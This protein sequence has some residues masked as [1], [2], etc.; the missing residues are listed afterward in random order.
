MSKQ[1]TSDKVAAAPTI[2]SQAVEHNGFVFVSGQVPIRLDGSIVE[3][4]VREKFEQ[5]VQNIQ[6]ILEAA[7]TTVANCVSVTIY[8]TDMGQLPELN[9]IYA[10]F[11]GDPLPARAAIGV[12][13]LPLGATIELSVVAAK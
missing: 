3:G 10:Q 12:Q 4:G 11:F 9:E 1:I 8:L 2:F 7:G 6:Y 5:I 13:A